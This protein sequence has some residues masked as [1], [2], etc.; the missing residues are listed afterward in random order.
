[1]AIDLILASINLLH[2]YDIMAAN[3]DLLFLIGKHIEV[4]TSNR[5]MVNPV[6]FQTETLHTVSTHP[7]SKHLSTEKLRN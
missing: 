3:G 5:R 6:K 4:C 2:R 7:R 1:M